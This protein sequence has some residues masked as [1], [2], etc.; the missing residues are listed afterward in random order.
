MTV[1]KL[2]ADLGI[3]K[4]TVSEI[5]DWGSLHEM[6]CGEFMLWL[7]QLEQKEHHATVSNDLIQTTINGTECFSNRS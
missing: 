5:F 2:E 3:P 6:C 7:L 1:Q 4:T